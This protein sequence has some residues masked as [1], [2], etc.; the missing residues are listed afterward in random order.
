MCRDIRDKLNIDNIAALRERAVMTMEARSSKPGA[1]SI[2][3]ER[4]GPSVCTARHPLRFAN[5]G[6]RSTAPAFVN[7]SKKAELKEGS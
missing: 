6:S 7:S 1:R 4:L 5:K 2:N 3:H